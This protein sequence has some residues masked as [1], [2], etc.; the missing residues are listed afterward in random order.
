MSFH[1]SKFCF[2]IPPPPHPKWTNLTDTN[3]IHLFMV[4]W[5]A[6]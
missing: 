3:I 6:Y 2:V 5:Y 1:R 4:T